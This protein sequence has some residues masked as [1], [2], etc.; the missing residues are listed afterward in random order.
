MD[1]HSSGNTSV[2]IFRVQSKVFYNPWH[3]RRNTL[4]K[5]RLRVW[6]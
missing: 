1:S 5:A 4:T 3:V 2:D 6:G